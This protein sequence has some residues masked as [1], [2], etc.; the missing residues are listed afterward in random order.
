[1]TYTVPIVSDTEKAYLRTDGQYSKVYLAFPQPAIVFKAH[2]NQ[3][4]IEND[5]ITQITY[6]NVDYGTY[7]SII[8]NMTLLVGTAEGD[9]DLG[10]ARVRKAPTSTVIYIG[11][12]AEVQFANNVHLTVIREFGIWPRHKYT[13]S[14]SE[15]VDYMDHDIVYTNQHEILDPVPVL[16][17]DRVLFYQGVLGG[18]NTISTYP[19]AS[20]SYCLSSTVNAYLWTALGAS[21]T[22]GLTTATPTITYNAPGTYLIS[23]R[24]T[25]VEGAI[26]TGYRTVVVYDN[27]AQPVKDFELQ[28]CDGSYDDGGWNFKVKMYDNAD[29]SLVRDRAQVILF[30]RDWYGDLTTLTSTGIS[31]ETSS[32]KIKKSSGLTIFLDD[33]TIRVSGST[34]N[35]GIYTIDHTASGFI[36]VNEDLIDE[37]AGDSVTIE[38][39]NHHT[40]VSLG[41][42]TG[43]ENVIASGWI[44]Q[45][46]IVMDVEG[47]TAVFTVH[48]PKEWLDKMIGF[49]SGLFHSETAPEEWNYMLDLTVDKGIWDILHWRATV[50]TM[51][52]VFLTG[53]EQLIP[54]MESSTIGSLWQQVA[55]MASSTMLA[56]ACCNRYGQLFVEVPGNL[57]SID[58]RAYTNV[59]T[60]E[61]YDR[62]G[63][64]EV[65]RITVPPV[66]QIDLSGVWYDGVEGCAVRGMSNGKIFNRYGIVEIVDKLI[67]ADQDDCTELA[68]LLYA[69]RN[70]PYPSLGFTFACNIRKIDICPEQQLEVVTATDMNP[71]EIEISDKS[72]PRT[73]SI[74]FDKE[75]YSL[76][77]KVDCEPETSIIAPRDDGTIPIPDVPPD[78][79][80]NHW[81][82]PSIPHIPPIPQPP[83]PIPLPPNPA[84]CP[85]DSPRTFYYSVWSKVG[86]KGLLGTSEA[87]RSAWLWFPAVI[88]KS[89]ATY[90]TTL[91]F[92]VSSV[93]NSY[94]YL[95]IFAVDRSGA[96]IASGSLG[97]IGSS[98]NLINMQATFSLP[99]ALTIAGFQL[100]IDAGLILGD[101][102]TPLYEAGDGWTRADTIWGEVYTSGPSPW[103]PNL[104]GWDYGVAQW[105]GAYMTGDAGGI[106]PWGGIS[107]NAWS[108]GFDVPPGTDPDYVSIY[109]WYN[110]QT[111]NESGLPD[112]LIGMS[113]GPPGHPWYIDGLAPGV[114]EDTDSIAGTMRLR[115]EYDYVWGK[116]ASVYITWPGG[117][118]S[119]LVSA[120]VTIAVI[121]SGETPFPPSVGLGGVYIYNVC[122]S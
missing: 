76:S 5:Q 117:I 58:G 103:V 11:E 122:A 53:S 28:S 51:M 115:G 74:A 106:T 104:D 12:T 93:G 69:R 89:T 107:F 20:R 48:G 91:R 95:H 81:D 21:A 120:G 101:G 114:Y 84:D 32:H 7:T 111:T 6:D 77:T 38:V 67:F 23:C 34:L 16:G 113:S 22:S 82:P 88:R 83:I 57:V 97:A 44:S 8:P 43:C 25:T 24:L 112:I 86:L 119:S 10:I 2:V 105:S 19:S 87:E 36:V 42:E 3:S 35:D 46:D 59:M 96:K 56:H 90:V 64:I 55:T 45:E 98:G 29:L 61:A 18:A 75:S 78:D 116:Q 4:N 108:G 33:T 65:S 72:F 85:D 37:A 50:T 14:G 94:Q 70:N 121:I 66:S 15:H 49:I 109:V 27:T 54:T 92:T 100:T 62:V 73:I 68:G 118:G 9:H 60:V 40:E 99:A 79:P 26:F 63:E 110:V 1:M 13:Q 52:D 17:P 47:G 39:L 30:S 80:H 102:L 41:P 71:R 31:F